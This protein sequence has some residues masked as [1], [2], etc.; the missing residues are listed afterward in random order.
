MTSVVRLESLD[1][2]GLVTIDEPPVN[3]LTAALVAGLAQA[4]D[5]FEQDRSLR[6]LVFCCAGRTFIAGGDLRAFDDPAFG[7]GPYNR[8]LARIE[9]LDRPVV[10]ALHGSVLGGG[11]ELAMAC[12]YRVALRGTRLGQPEIKIGVLPGSLG[13]QRLPR[14]IDAAVSVEMMLSGA[15]IGAGRALELGLVDAIAEG[16]AAREAGL[17]HARSVLAHGGG[18]RPTRARPVRREGLTAAYFSD[19]RALAET[20]LR[21]YP[22]AR[23][24]VDA[25]EAGVTHGF[26][27]GE[28]VEAERFD[29]CRRSGP[30]RAMR[31]LFFAAREAR[32]IPSLP[33]DMPR[34]PVHKVGVI[35]A[36]TMGRGIAM[37]FLDIGLPTVL[38]EVEQEALDRGIAALRQTYEANVRKGRLD[39]AQLAER[40]ALAHGTLDDDD[41]GDC[42]LVI[43]AV[44]E[45]MALK[46]DVLARLGRLC[47]PGAILATNTS[48]LDVDELARASGRAH[49]VIG[50]HFFSPA[51]IMRLLE[52]VRGG[53]TAPDVLMTVLDLAAA[54]GKTPVVSGVC[55]GFIGNRMAEVY[56]REN[57][58]LL[59]EGASPAE[60]DG[61]VEDMAHWGMA[62]G[63]C[64]MLDLAGID[65]GA[66]TLIELTMNGGLPHDPAYRVVC[67]QLNADGR[68]GQKTGSGYYRYEDGRTPLPEPRT[69]AVC[70]ELA[71][72]HGIARRAAISAGEIRERLLLPLINEAA[73]IL[74][75]G[76]A[77]RPG[78]VD[79]V[80][81]AGYGFPD[82]RGGPLWMA[83]DIGLPKVVERLRHYASRQGGDPHGY[84]MPAALLVEQAGRGQRLSD[85][86]SALGMG[87][88]EQ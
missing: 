41:L 63:P 70:R 81:T 25:V 82:H 62:M 74:E 32:R 38:R 12:H 11:L 78:D 49:D 20:R 28:R 85:W 10:A 88:A 39:A 83:D 56:M 7:T 51:N 53:A 80:W 64:R 24:I 43:E 8:T 86:R 30:S 61:A 21:A 29:A 55:Y 42:D 66:R 57:E 13:T 36:G 58:F 1:A 72:R 79:V 35:G 3:A 33:A 19:Q 67:R 17:A 31:H 6:A 71:A 59:L 65:V 77:L 22:A 68:W 84:W 37:N 14:L 69:D 16:D 60:I 23:A 5:A 34:R 76:I 47:K 75:E 46:R 2:I 18:P 54:I 87:A 4:V 50:T 52:V 48:T 27:A 15:P 26:D 45:D 40:M 44:F 9:A 73:K